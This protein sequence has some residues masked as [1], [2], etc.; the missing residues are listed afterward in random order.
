MDIK[1]LAKLSYDRTLAQKQLEERQQSRL[2][3]TYENGI[4]IC[5]TNLICLL[6]SY[7]HL[8]YIVILDSCKIPRKIHVNTLLK[9]VQERH[10]EILNDWLVEYNK[11]AKIRTI[12][13]VLE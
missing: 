6:H 1:E 9:L 8:E 5:D 12:K 10:Q 7:V 4:W 11:L 2:L 3:L 13:H